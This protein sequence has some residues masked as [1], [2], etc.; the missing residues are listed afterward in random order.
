MVTDTVVE[1]VVQARERGEA[2]ADVARAYAPS[3]GRR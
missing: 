3:T 2:V 1:Q